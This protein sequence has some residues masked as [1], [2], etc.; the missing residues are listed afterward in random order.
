MSSVQKVINEIF[1]IL[2][3][4]YQVLEIHVYF[5]LQHV[6][7]GTSRVASSHQLL[8]AG[9]YHNRQC[10]SIPSIVTS[11]QQGEKGG[12][13]PCSQV[14]KVVEATGLKKG[15]Q[16]GDFHVCGDLFMFITPLAAVG[17]HIH[18]EAHILLSNSNS[19]CSHFPPHLL[20][21]FSL[22]PPK[23]NPSSYLLQSPT[24]QIS[25][26]KIIIGGQWTKSSPWM[27]AWPT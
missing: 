27:F 11:C 18:S 14:Q 6:S 10:R 16:F 4:L 1:Y 7:I 2:F 8:V 21:L 26:A 24:F 9:G 20:L 19:L 23:F 13:F 25:M 22:P 17:F 5:H 12:F 15:S 3:F